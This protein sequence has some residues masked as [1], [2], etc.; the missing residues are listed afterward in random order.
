MKL[1]PEEWCHQFI[2]AEIPLLPP[3]SRSTW[4]KKQKE[5]RKNVLDFMIHSCSEACV[6]DGKC[7]K[8]FPKPFSLTDQVSDE[9]YPIYRRRA[10]AKSEEERRQN[11]ELY[12]ETEDKISRGLNRVI[13]NRHVVAHNPFLIN[14]YKSQLVN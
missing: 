4:Y 6:V 9:A 13:D 7:S 1:T 12:G 5:Y 11:P 10:P 3:P 14:K 2:S 8:R